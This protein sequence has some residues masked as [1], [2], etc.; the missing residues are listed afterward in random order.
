MKSTTL[1]HDRVYVVKLAYFLIMFSPKPKGS[2]IA[3][4]TLFL[5]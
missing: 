2:F 1:T 4:A 5:K 3:V